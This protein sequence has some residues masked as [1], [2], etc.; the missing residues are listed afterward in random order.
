MEELRLTKTYRTPQALRN[1]GR[2]YSILLPPF[3]APYYVDLARETGSLGLGIALAVI[4]SLTLTGLFESME[5]LE[6]PFVAPTT[7]EGVGAL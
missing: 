1:F 3:Y 5:V 2:V 6:D 7:L 4:V